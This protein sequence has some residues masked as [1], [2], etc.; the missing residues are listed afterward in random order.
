MENNLLKAENSELEQQNYNLI[1][2]L[3][4]YKSLL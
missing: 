3:K 1:H 4:Q 2:K